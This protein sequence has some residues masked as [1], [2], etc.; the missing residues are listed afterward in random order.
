M[1]QHFL[2]FFD[3]RNLPIDMLVLHCSNQPSDIMIDT[4]KKLS[5][6]CH[7]II[8]TDG[9]IT[10]CVEEQNRAWHA[11][12]GFWRKANTSI[13]SRS[14]GIE[15]SS[16]S[17]GQETY[18]EAQIQ[19]LIK[20][21]TDIIKRH[22]IPAHNIVGHSDIAPTRK[23][24]PGK[25]FPWQQLAQQGIGLWYSISDAKKIKTN[26]IE[27]LLHSIGYDTSNMQVTLASAYAFCRHFI[28]QFV[29]YDAD[30]YHL[31]DNILPSNF[32]FINDST[33]IQILKAVSF[34]Y[35]K[36]SS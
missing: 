14:I 12:V 17:L 8:D 34:A 25:A 21:S 13:N 1:K 11:G 16:P 19:S 24:D 23:A 3:E 5:L 4:L 26:D 15:I 27:E 30:V 6:S 32:D 28:P 10:Q 29:E 36:K 31:V 2:P 22:K 20:L 18:P 35:Q 33:F 9:T 7:Y